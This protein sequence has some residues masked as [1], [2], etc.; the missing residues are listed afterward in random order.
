MRG[1]GA[2]SAWTLCCQARVL[3]TALAT[4]R[5]DVAAVIACGMAT[6]FDFRA[7]DIK[8]GGEA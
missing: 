6:Q 4:T 7:N 2:T 1:F 5:M 3:R 8:A